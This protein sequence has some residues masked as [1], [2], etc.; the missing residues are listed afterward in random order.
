MSAQTQNRPLLVLI[1]GPYMS[2]TDGDPARIAANRAE[3]ERHALPIYERGHLP[4]IGEWMALPIIHSA[5]GKE[6]GDEVFQAYQ[7]PVAHRLIER[8]DAVLRLPGAS[9]GA[10]MDVARAQELGLKVVYD[11][12]ELP[13]RAA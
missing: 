5:G 3:L 11:V 6:H 10:D 8:C 2:G 9:R 7:Y 13:L 1:A 12:N 4:L